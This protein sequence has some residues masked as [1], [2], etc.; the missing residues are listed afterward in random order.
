MRTLNDTAGDALV[1]GVA[2]MK[3]TF[4]GCISFISENEINSSAQSAFVF[5][6]KWAV[7][8]ILKV[9]GWFFFCIVSSSLSKRL[10]QQEMDENAE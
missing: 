9:V 7:L 10:L 8:G 2:V 5:I 3:K 6:D 1:I 4:F